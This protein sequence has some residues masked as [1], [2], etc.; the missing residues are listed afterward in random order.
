MNRSLKAAFGFAGVDDHYFITAVVAPKQP[1]RVDYRL[2][3]VTLPGEPTGAHYVVLVGA[4]RGSAEGRRAYFRGPEG[5]R[6]PR[7]RRPRSGPLDRLRHLRL[8][9]RAAAARAEVGERLRR[10]LRLVDRRAH[11]AHQPRH[12]PA[13]PQERRLDAEDAGDPA[14]GEGDPGSLREPEDERPGA[15]EDEHGAD[16]PVPRARREPRERL[17]P[18]APDVPGALRVLLDALGGDR[19]ARRAV[20]PVDPRSGRRPTRTTC[21]RS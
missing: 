9:R 8:A 7:R 10:Q 21:S 19:A 6:H 3:D 11:G 16:E 12:V 5:F 15:A 1:L 2:L 4:L 18:D 13:P 14:G 17:R 20:H